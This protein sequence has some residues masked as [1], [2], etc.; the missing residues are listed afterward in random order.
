MT[1]DPLSI[2][3]RHMVPILLHSGQRILEDGLSFLECDS[4]FQQ[5]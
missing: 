2:L 1:E 3:V 4:V 5:V